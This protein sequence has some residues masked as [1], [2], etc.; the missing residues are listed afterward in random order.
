MYLKNGLPRFPDLLIFVGRGSGKNGYLAFEDFC[1]ISP[2]NSVREYDIDICATVEEQAKIS[3]NDIYNILENPTN[4]EYKKILKKHFYWNKEII[5][6]KKNRSSVKFR[7]NNAKSKDGLRSGKVDFDE[8]HA[9]ESYDNIKV[10]TTALGKKAHPRRTYITTNG[11]ISDGVLDDLIEKSNRILNDDAKDN[12]L[13]PF[14]CVIDKEEEVHNEE[15]WHKAN[16]SLQ[17]LPN[18]LYEIK[19]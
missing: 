10:F 8:V 18:L 9:Y 16:P 5:T 4:Q 14:C 12:G 11:D 6:G 15:N 3:F 7:T 13:L 1:L 19:K 17:Y 2:Y